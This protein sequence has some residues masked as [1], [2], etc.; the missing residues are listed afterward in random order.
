MAISIVGAM[1]FIPHGSIGEKV[2][3]QKILSH[4]NRNTWSL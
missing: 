1:A 2:C 3:L 4:M